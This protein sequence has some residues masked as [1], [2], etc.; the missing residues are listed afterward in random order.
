M[1]LTKINFGW[2]LKNVSLW[3]LLG[4]LSGWIW[5]SMSLGS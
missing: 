4:Y 1:G 2:Y 3:V 5:L